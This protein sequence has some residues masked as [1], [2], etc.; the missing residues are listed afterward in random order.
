M[1]LSAGML[2]MVELY[3]SVYVQVVF[4]GEVGFRYEHY[5]DLLVF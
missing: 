5:V 4:V 3:V 2:G 1:G